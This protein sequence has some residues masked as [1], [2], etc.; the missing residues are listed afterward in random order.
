MEINPRFWENKKVLITGHTGFKG[1]WLCLWLNKLGANVSGLSL[2]EPVSS[3]NMFSV[4]N[5]EKL[6]NDERGDISDYE[7]CL[8][9]VKNNEP[10]I[11]FHLAAQPLVRL[12]YVAPLETYNTNIIGTANILEAIR[13][14]ESVRTI[15][16]I[17]T[18]KCYENIEEDHAYVETDSLGGYDPYSSSK[19]CAEHVA[20]AYYRSFFKQKNIG[21]A[22]AR[23][24]NVIGGGDWSADRLIPDAVKTWSKNEKLIIRYPQATRPWQHVLE[25]INGYLLLAEHLWG[26]SSEFSGGWNFGPD[27]N[28]VKTVQDTVELASKVWGDY[29]DWE[30]S[31][32]KHL[33]EA[34]LLQLNSDKADSRLGWHPTLN[35]DEAVNHTINW[36]RTYYTNKQKIIEYTLNQISEYESRNI[37][38]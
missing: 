11:V 2:E 12:S 7:T 14:C 5:I 37:L 9:A 35:F 23:A 27:K 36:Y 15:V 6:V 17:T 25:P 21:L 28:S 18:D 31:S 22:T 19:A 10:E 20:S 30:S 38:V 32:D 29:A 34:N 3:P 16:T 24:G 8:G 1:S 33:H 4:L 26:N 13:N